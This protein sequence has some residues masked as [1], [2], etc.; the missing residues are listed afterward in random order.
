MNKKQAISRLRREIEEMCAKYGLILT[1]HEGRIGLM[2]KTTKNMVDYL[3][4]LPC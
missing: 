1:V 2:D 4:D 3:E